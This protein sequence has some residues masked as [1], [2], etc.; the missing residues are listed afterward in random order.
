[1]PL[2]TEE[3]AQTDD[4]LDAMSYGPRSRAECCEGPDKGR[5]AKLYSFIQQSDL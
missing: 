1:M 5:V 3:L 2:K 4:I